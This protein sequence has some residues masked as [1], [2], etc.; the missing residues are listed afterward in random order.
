MKSN[1][2]KFE[3]EIRIFIDNFNFFIKK[4]ENIK[5]KLIKKYS[6][7][8]E[9][10]FP[11]NNRDWKIKTKCI[12]I[13]S[14]SNSQDSKILFSHIKITN[15]QGFNFKQSKYPGGKI[16]LF[17]GEKIYAKKILKD[18]GFNHIFT[19]CK[20]DGRLYEIPILKD[21]NNFIIAVEKIEFW[22]NNNIDKKKTIYL[23]ELEIWEDTIKNVIIEFKEKLRVLD[24]PE[25]KITS[26]SVPYIIYK[27]LKI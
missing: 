3:S 2:T 12:R 13:R 26:D 16:N 5:A 20:A 7:I 21:C 8:D 17:T 23:A 24:I 25:S 11:I 22:K 4:L 15:N 10:Y 27:L 9:I 14:Y 6:F 1:Y 19:I 18:L